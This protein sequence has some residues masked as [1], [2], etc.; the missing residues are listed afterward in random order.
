MCGQ[1]GKPQKIEL[2]QAYSKPP[3]VSIE[4]KRDL[5]SLCGCNAIKSQHQEFYRNLT[6]ISEDKEN[7]NNI[8]SNEE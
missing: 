5:L 1:K 4:K 8:N 7:M 6:T 3:G 2:I